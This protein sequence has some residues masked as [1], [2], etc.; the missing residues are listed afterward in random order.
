MEETATGTR[1]SE[2][3]RILY[4][5]D[6]QANL[7]NLSLALRDEYEVLTARSGPEAIE[8]FRREP[9]LSVVLVDQ[10]MPGM[11][12][13][14]TLA[15]LLRID[16]DP[17]RIVVTAYANVDDIVDAVNRGSVY[18]YILKPWELQAL[19][20][21]LRRAYQAFWLIKENKRLAAELM[22]RNADLR[23]ANLTLSNLNERLRE[24]IQRRELA[25]ASF[26]SLNEK[27][28][29]LVA[30]RTAELS[31]ANEGLRA[32]VEERRRVERELKQATD[33]L[34]L[35]IEA[36]TSE[37]RGAHQ[38]LLQAEKLS[39]VGRL[40]SSIAHEFNNPI[41]GVLN[42]LHSLRAGVALGREEAEMVALAIQECNRIAAFVRDLQ[43][44][45]RPS[46]GISSPTDV[47]EALDAM[48]LFCRK[49]FAVRK[50]EVER[51]YA[52]DLPAVV[53]I[54]DQ[55]RQVML[56]LLNNAMQAMPKGGGRI[57]VSTELTGESI[58]IRL[59]DTG[60]GIAPEHLGRIFEPFF[61][62][63][64]PSKGTGLGLPISQA[65]VQRHGG[66]MDVESTPGQGTTFTVA[67]PLAGAPT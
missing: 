15:E 8:L 6:E 25:E 49:E 38:Q 5:D 31:R 21:T 10:R 65:I 59:Q 20:L 2:R 28:E 13:V 45:S 41:F 3:P 42:V 24:D 9:G 66:T 12:G 16:P 40:A 48:L 35:R 34:E 55:I 57:R 29:A 4:V 44:F 33:E 17:V 52:T 50:I 51:A 58:L 18:H 43:S 46:S 26:R 22:E 39:A 32:E 53:A 61:T 1:S 63:K 37:L 30:E 14:D 62:T 60:T 36:R 64:P 54:G 23:R 7:T 56:N 47:H 11:A 19:R 27:L 67:L